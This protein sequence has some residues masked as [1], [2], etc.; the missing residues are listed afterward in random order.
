MVNQKTSRTV[1]FE[2]IDWDPPVQKTL[3]W[4]CACGQRNFK[5]NIWDFALV[6]LCHTEAL[7]MNQYIIILSFIIISKPCFLVVFQHITAREVF[8][9]HPAHQNTGCESDG[10]VSVCVATSCVLCRQHR[11]WTDLESAE[12]HRGGVHACDDVKVRGGEMALIK[13]RAAVAQCESEV[14]RETEWSPGSFTRLNCVKC[15][16]LAVGQCSRPAL[17][18]CTVLVHQ[19]AAC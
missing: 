17:S 6:E 19:A 3:G 18:L 16:R 7:E 8:I 1:V 15:L 13:S 10:E 4:M 5:R 12:G 11:K 14:N 9:P 2:V